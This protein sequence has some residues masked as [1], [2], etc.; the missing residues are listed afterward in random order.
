MKVVGSIMLILIW[1]M[2]SVTSYAQVDQVNPLSRIVMM[3]SEPTSLNRLQQGEGSP[4]EQA[5]WRL[6]SASKNIYM[7]TWDRE[8]DTEAIISELNAHA[9][10]IAH[11][12]D[13]FVE[14]RGNITPNDPEFSAQWWLPRIK[15]NQAWTQ[16]TGGL[17]DL[18]DTIVIAVLEQQGPDFGHEDLRDDLFWINRA[19]IPG[20]GIDDDNNGYIDDYR[21]INIRTRRDNHAVD[22]DRHCTPVSAIIGANSNNGI[23]VS[24]INWNIK[25]LIISDVVTISQIIEGYEYVIQMRSRYEASGGAE[26]ALIVATNASFGRDS[27]FPQDFPAWCAMYDAMGEYGILTAASVPNRNVNID[28][29]G[30]LPALCPSP[31]VIA[32]TS[33]NEADTKTPGAGFGE[34]NVDLGA[35]GEGVLTALPGD[36]YSNWSGTSAAAP[37]VSGAIALLYSMPFEAIALGLRDSPAETGLIVKDAI[38]NGV[39]RLRDLENR[40]A[41]KGRLNIGKSMTELAKAYGR[42]P[43]GIVIDQIYPNPVVAEL[44]YI[45]NSSEFVQ[46]HDVVVFN[47][48]GQQVLTDKKLPSIFGQDKYTLDVSTLAPGA[49]TLTVRDQ[50]K[51]ASVPFIKTE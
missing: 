23:G 4:L 35:P 39:D 46:E 16:S 22:T 12:E 2:G 15:A 18:G 20:N 13:A 48:L 51:V 14:F 1:L 32:V 36:A 44:T 29:E 30:D 5:H 19:E 31:Y 10:V 6:L 45:F 41:S 27:S 9:G 33:T 25:L 26:G 37:M 8:E 24:G 17:T 34:Q 11:H 3:A 50:K 38:L 40:V 49:Y 47:M 7:I 28:I 21:G 43:R 42:D